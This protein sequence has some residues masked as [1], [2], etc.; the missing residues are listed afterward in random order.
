M[1]AIGSRSV[2]RRSKRSRFSSASM[3]YRSDQ[4]PAC[5]APEPCR[6]RPGLLPERPRERRLRLVADFRRHARD[7]EPV[8]CSRSAAIISRTRV[9]NAPTVV[10]VLRSKW[11]MNVARDIA[12][13]GSCARS[14][15]RRPGR[16]APVRRRRRCA[17]FA[18]RGPECCVGRRPR[19]VRSII[20]SSTLPGAE[21]IAAVPS[22]SSIASSRMS[23]LSIRSAHPSRGSRRTRRAPGSGRLPKSMAPAPG[24]N[25]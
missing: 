2:V 7:R 5:R 15:S 11:R 25:V 16:R 6:C 23:A 17:V 21:R 20:V 18:G 13:P 8:V 3:G 12:S 1:S 22:P 19:D 9:T 14:T 10:P 4:P 24:P